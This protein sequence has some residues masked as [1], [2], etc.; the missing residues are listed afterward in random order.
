MTIT[1]TLAQLCEIALIG[2]CAD[3]DQA[4][5]I[6][7]QLHIFARGGRLVV[8]ATD[9]TVIA[10]L[11]VGPVTGPVDALIPAAEVAAAA[12]E[13]A[14]RATVDVRGAEAK[15]NALSFAD[16][17]WDMDARALLTDGLGSVGFSPPLSM[18][19][20]TYPPTDQLFDSVKDA[21]PLRRPVSFDVRK[22]RQIHSTIGTDRLIVMETFANKPKDDH[23]VNPNGKD[24]PIRLTSPEV[25]GWTAL[26]MPVRL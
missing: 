19:Q 7:C 17:R 15:R 4:R 3:T 20:R 23:R 16:V 10:R 14:R 13:L 11:S 25:P 18:G 5:P 21:P 9:S 8:E 6:L 1:T 22:L 2:R 26:L 12:K 24:R